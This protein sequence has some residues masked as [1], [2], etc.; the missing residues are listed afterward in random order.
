M[1]LRL[2][3]EIESAGL[4]AE[5]ASRA[6]VR[7]IGAALEA[8]DRATAQGKAAVDEDL[9]LPPRDRRGDRQS[10]SSPASCSSSA[11]TSSRAAS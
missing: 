3:V 4:A 9:A 5:R 10:R 8:M 2:C 7:A 11:A 6:Q 1:E